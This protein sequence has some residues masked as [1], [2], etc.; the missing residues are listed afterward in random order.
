[1]TQAAPALRSFQQT[2]ALRSCLRAAPALRSFQ[3]TLA[4]K[5][6]QQRALPKTALHRPAPQSRTGTRLSPQRTA[7]TLCQQSSAL[8][9]KL[10]PQ[11]PSAII[12]LS[13]LQQSEHAPVG[14]ALHLPGDAAWETGAHPLLQ[15]ATHPATHP[16]QAGP[17]ACETAAHLLL[18]QLTLTAV[19]P[20]QA[21]A[22]VQP[23]AQANPLS[24]RHALAAPHPRSAGAAQPGGADPLLHQLTHS[25]SPRH[26]AGGG[27]QSR[28][29]GWWLSLPAPHPRPAGVAQPREAYPL[30]R[31]TLAACRHHMP[32][33]GAQLTGACPLCQ[34]APPP[35]GGPLPSRA[36][37]P[38]R[39]AA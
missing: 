10:A 24:R 15:Q 4:L 13:A 26:P 1:M 8:S 37:A 30:R 35:L 23:K 5:S 29:F 39:G 19:P 12:A 36:M 21:G 34:R 31:Q 25:A 6:C 2:L 16:P 20:R 14:A 28:G 9:S 38:L 3:Q 17:S 32:R 11:A 7:E 18:H 22:G 33:E 27:A